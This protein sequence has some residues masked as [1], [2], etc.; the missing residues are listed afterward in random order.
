MTVESPYPGLRPFQRDEAH[1]FFGREEQTDELLR[2]LQQTRFLA[3][4]GPS[5]CGKSSLVRAGMLAALETGF[6]VGAGS[7]WEFAV[8]RPGSHPIHRLAAA[9]IKKTSLSPP[10]KADAADA[11]GLLTASLRRGPLGL[12]EALQITPLAPGT[13]LLILVDQF[14]EIFRF[15][16]EGGGDEADAFVSLLI[17]TARQRE[18]S[19]YVVIT[20]RSDFFGH[21]AVFAGL[22][23]VINES[24]YLTPRL[25]REQRQAAIVGPARV[26]A[27][28]VEPTL[29]NRL[30]NEMGSD[31]DQL[32]LMQHLLM[33]MWTYRETTTSAAA[34]PG[35]DATPRLLTVQ[36]YMQVGGLRHALSNHADEAYGALSMQQKKIAQLMFRRLS[37]RGEDQLDIRRPT[38]AGEIASL[39]DVALD[40]VAAVVDVFR[41]PGVSFLMPAWPEPIDSANILD[42]SHESLI[43]Q[44]NRL[45][46]WAREEGQSAETYRFLE[47]TARRW[48][49]G[50]AALW[51]TPNLEQALDWRTRERPTA[52]WA[53]R[54]RGDFALA[55]AFLD[56]SEQARVAREA[57]AEAARQREVQQALRLADMEQKRADAERRRAETQIAT[58][59]RLVALS[60]VMGVIFLVAVATAAFALLKHNEA[61]AARHEAEAALDQALNVTDAMVKLFY[62]PMDNLIAI[63]TAEI[64]RQLPHVAEAIEEMTDSSEGIASHLKFLNTRASLHNLFGDLYA[65]RGDFDDALAEVDQAVRMMKEA[66]PKAEKLADTSQEKQDLFDNLAESYNRIG[67]YGEFHRDPEHRIAASERAIEYGNRLTQLGSNPE[68]RRDL[69]L[70][71]ANASIEYLNQGDRD[72]ASRYIDRLLQMVDN[73]KDSKSN[74][75]RRV[76]ANSYAVFAMFNSFTGDGGAAGKFYENS[77]SELEQSGEREPLGLDSLYQIAKLRFWFGDH[78]ASQNQTELAAQEHG[79]AIDAL[80]QLVQRDPDNALWQ[81][82]LANAMLFQGNELGRAGKDDEALA[83][84]RQSGAIWYQLRAHN[85]D[86]VQALVGL[87]AYRNERVSLLQKEGR[88]QAALREYRHGQGLLQRIFEHLSDG[89]YVLLR[90][91]DP[92]GGGVEESY[93]GGNGQL[94]APRGFGY[95][96]MRTEYDGAGHQKQRAFY[97]ADGQLAV[98]AMCGFAMVRDD[99]DEAGRLE[100][101]AFYGPDEKPTLAPQHGYAI[102]RRQYDQGGRLIE[103]A[104]YGP[105][106]QLLLH[107]KN[108]YAMFRGKYNARGDVIEMAM[109]G[110]DGEL[111]LH[112]EYGYATVRRK[113]SETGNLIEQ[114]FYDEDGDLVMCAKCG[115]AILRK[116][117]DAAGNVVKETYYDDQ[118]ELMP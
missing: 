56:A 78:L 23:E 97:G 11:L 86:N 9:L 113:Y 34:A 28:D 82:A 48:R 53:Q 52:V 6:M 92:D 75:D 21:C 85:S 93:Y 50:K 18:V 71:Y 60:A 107:P 43:R 39:C 7:R 87:L 66:E 94:F 19:V 79:K 29:V 13:N 74:E 47:Q 110:A 16:R 58:N 77:I 49:D 84:F 46:E 3:V 96:T 42:I 33:R 24:Q 26:Y 22:P 105:D 89:N 72:H 51:G 108:G 118:G 62:D 98:C 32:P 5:G 8:M 10:D 35:A 27:G 69:M 104:Y 68:W 111:M 12:V 20:M 73:I 76:L 36:D 15:R 117:Y 116:Q 115:Y 91:P 102:L 88:H 17:E 67:Q 95:A 80:K 57:E 40:E 103:E 90:K 38:P 112:P 44:W 114:V 14:E 59:R 99:Y 109:Y 30:L 4:V 65:R 31:P 106:E 83:A 45:K 61:L 101:E 100:E 70:N 2:R 55:M 1:L 37:E 81:D 41:A 63:P 64:Q 54:Y 25:S